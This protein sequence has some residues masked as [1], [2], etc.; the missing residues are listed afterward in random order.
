MGVKKE[1]LVNL[2]DEFESRKSKRILS[3]SGDEEFAREVRSL[4]RSL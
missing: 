3:L 2:A 1:G 4:L